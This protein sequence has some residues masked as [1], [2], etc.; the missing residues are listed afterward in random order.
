V[1]F[2]EDDRIIDVDGREIHLSRTDAAMSRL[3]LRNAG[4]VVPR[5]IL[6]H[7]PTKKY[8]ER[9]ATAKEGDQ[10]TV[11]ASQRSNFK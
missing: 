11:S 3:L 6:F 10:V 8:E 5:R 7:F 4:E 9:V 1:V 2:T